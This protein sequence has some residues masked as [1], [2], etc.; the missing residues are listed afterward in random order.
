MYIYAC[1]FCVF[2]RTQTA[3]RCSTLQHTVSGICSKCRFPDGRGFLGQRRA[4][5]ARAHGPGGGAVG[6][7]AAAPNP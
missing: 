1:F 2:S 7:D 4:N 6:G 3:T 5:A